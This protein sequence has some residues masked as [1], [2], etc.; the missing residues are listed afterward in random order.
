MIIVFTLSKVPVQCT[1]KNKIRFP[2]PSFWENSL[3]PDL[4]TTTYIV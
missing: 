4:D 1:L 2:L 3:R